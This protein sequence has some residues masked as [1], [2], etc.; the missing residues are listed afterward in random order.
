MNRRFFI[1]SLSEHL[2][3]DRKVVLVKCVDLLVYIDFLLLGRSIY[4][5][6]VQIYSM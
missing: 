2:S 3:F 6:N 4:T 1:V 5:F